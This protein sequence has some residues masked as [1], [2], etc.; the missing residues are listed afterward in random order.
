MDAGLK[1]D[2]TS[3]ECRKTMIFR[4]HFLI[5]HVPLI[6][7]SRTFHQKDKDLLHYKAGFAQRA[8]ESELKQK[9]NMRGWI[10]RM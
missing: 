6:I 2:P 7:L 3:M 10:D 1:I 5:H 8:R 9:D 4:P